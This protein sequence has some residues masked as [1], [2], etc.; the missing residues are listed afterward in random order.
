MGSV[1]DDWWNEDRRDLFRSIGAIASGEA[2]P[3]QLGHSLDTVLNDLELYDDP[4]QGAGAWLYENELLL[5]DRLGEEL[6]DLVGQAAPQSDEWAKVRATA[7]TLRTL[8]EKNGDF[9]G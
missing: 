9:T 6:H 3:E 2:S 7:A 1:A 4:R 8:M 5:A